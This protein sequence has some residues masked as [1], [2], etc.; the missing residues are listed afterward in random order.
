MMVW[1]YLFERFI[2][3]HYFLVFFFEQIYT[4]LKSFIGIVVKQGT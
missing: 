4:L 1:G 2:C 3:L